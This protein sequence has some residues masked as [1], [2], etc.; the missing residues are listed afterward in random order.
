MRITLFTI[1]FIHVYYSCFHY[2]ET[3]EDTM[4]LEESEATE[5]S[6]DT[7]AESRDQIE[8]VLAPQQAA[9]ESEFLEGP[10][11]SQQQDILHALSQATHAAGQQQHAEEV[12]CP[13]QEEP[14]GISG[15]ESISQSTSQI[16]VPSASILQP[17]SHGSKTEKE[18]VSFTCLHF[19]LLSCHSINF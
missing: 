1:S 8:V 17:H 16:E 5:V 10:T 18:Y 13:V 9:T 14:M 7:T 3:S 19:N 2:S 11:C 6:K 15:I 4:N 12:E